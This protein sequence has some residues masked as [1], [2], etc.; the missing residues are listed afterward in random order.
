MKITQILTPDRVAVDLA[1]VSKKAVLETLAGMLSSADPQLKSKDVFDSLLARERLGTTG[2]GA[3][4]A[5]PHGRVATGGRSI[6]AFLR[7]DEPINFDA[8]DNAP[9]DLF[10][11]LCVPEDAHQEH[12]D[13]LAA[14]ASR[15]SDQGFVDHLRAAA[16]A[17]DV[18][19]ALTAGNDAET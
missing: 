10:F 4:I 14:L 16:A 1:L 15:F 7:T 11:A 19:A 2:L 12:L 3:G 18:F 6:G 5:I 17:G 8:V 13:L 9:V